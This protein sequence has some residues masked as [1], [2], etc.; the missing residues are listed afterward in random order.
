MN[1]AP[2]EKATPGGEGGAGRPSPAS[3]SW[4]T[5]VLTQ[6]TTWQGPRANLTASEGAGTQSLA[7]LG[8]RR[9]C[10]QEPILCLCPE[11][12]QACAG[13]ALRGRCRPGRNAPHASSPEFL[14]LTPPWSGDH[15]PHLPG[16]SWCSE[17]GSSHNNRASG[18]YVFYLIKVPFICI[19][20]T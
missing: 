15:H 1:T 16:G 9:I 7:F 10:G 19:S 2:G 13:H 18:H 12:R 3:T 8:P 17:R 11:E 14:F 5:W 6:L 20:N 4:A